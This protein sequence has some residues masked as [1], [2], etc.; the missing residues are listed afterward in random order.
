MYAHNVTE[1]SRIV[2]I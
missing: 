1:N 2:S